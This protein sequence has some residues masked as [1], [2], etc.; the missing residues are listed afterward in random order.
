MSFSNPVSTKSVN[1]SHPTRK[2]LQKEIAKLH[3]QSAN[4]KQRL[5][6]QDDFQVK[7]DR[8]KFSL[9]K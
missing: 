3:L 4:T 1:I 7:N 9:N 2:L 5:Q 8:A 6:T